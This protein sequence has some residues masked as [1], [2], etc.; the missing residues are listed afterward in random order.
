MLLYFTSGCMK[1]QILQPWFWILYTR[2]LLMDFWG[3]EM[4]WWLTMSQFIGSV[5]PQCWRRFYGR[6]IKFDCFYAHT[7]TW[8]ES[9][10]FDVEHTCT[11]P[12]KSVIDRQEYVR[13]DSFGCKINNG[14]VHAQ[15]S[16]F[17]LQKMQLHS[18]ISRVYVSSSRLRYA[19]CNK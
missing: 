3:M 19:T 18:I 11:A 10:Q 12:D 6:T 17:M 8:A 7:L 4:C 15:Q 13:E 9:N 5:N 14:W 16:G 2:W 1:G